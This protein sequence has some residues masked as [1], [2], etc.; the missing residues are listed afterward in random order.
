MS[1]TCKHDDAEWH[2]DNQYCLECGRI[3]AWVCEA[4]HGE[5]FV[6][7]DEY[8]GDWINF[9]PDLITCPECRGEGKICEDERDA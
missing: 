8:E 7:E 4:C 9:G 6:Q 1:A 2:D 5:G 3:V